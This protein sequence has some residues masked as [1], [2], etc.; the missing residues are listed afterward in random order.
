MD[1]FAQRKFRLNWSIDNSL[2]T[3]TPAGPERLESY[4]RRSW[5][6]LYPF[7]PTFESYAMQAGDAPRSYDHKPGSCIYCGAVKY[8]E[9]LDR[10]LGGEHIIPEGLNGT[11]ELKEASCKRC[12]AAINPKEQSILR[13]VMWASR[14][15]LGMRMKRRKREGEIPC[16]AE[17]DG[18]MKRVML[19]PSEHP[20]FIVLPILDPPGLL[21]D[22]SSDQSGM[23]GIWVKAINYNSKDLS[24]RGLQAGNSG[25]FDVLHFLQILAKIAWSFVAAKIGIH[26]VQPLLTETIIRQYSLDEMDLGCYELIGGDSELEPASE[27]LHEIGWSPLGHEFGLYVSVRIRLFANLGAPTYHVFPA[28]VTDPD[29]FVSLTRCA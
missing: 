6:Q 15:N 10:R 24:E 11:L 3:N 5:R 4:A 25:E 7:P 16:M 21:S 22:R 14:F 9:G 17:V 29:L 8:E 26:K 13:G 28:L 2:I 19:H 23:H 20:S 18:L 27:N 1:P 12:E